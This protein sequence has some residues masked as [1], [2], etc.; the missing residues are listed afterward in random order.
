MTVMKSTGD[1]LRE[2][3]K[4][5]I[6]MGWA[7]FASWRGVPPVLLALIL[8]FAPL[9]RVIEPVLTRVVQPAAILLR[10]MA[11]GA[12]VAGTMHALSGATGIVSAQS[13]EGK[14][15]ESLFYRF[16]V[17]AP[18]I[19]KLYTGVGLPPGLTLNRL[20]GF[21][22]GVP[23][24]AGVF[25]ARLTAWRDS[26]GV[27]DSFTATVVFHIAGDLPPPIEIVSITPDRTVHLGEVVR[28]VVQA[29]PI[30]GELEYQWKRGSDDIPGA[31]EPFLVVATEEMMEGG[32][33]SVR[34]SGSGE[35]KDSDVIRVVVSGPLEARVPRIQI[36][37][38]L[39]DV[40][41]VAIA[42]RRYFLEHRV[43]FEGEGKD[44]RVIGEMLAE[45]SDGR[46]SVHGIE[47]AMGLFRLRVEPHDL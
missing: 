25:E 2:V 24:E 41:F 18:A 19:P 47:G 43:R 27:G 15:G 32:E 11:P 35:P 29:K 4:T 23:T 37:E 22:T 14:V 39:V 8:Q 1:V 45:T 21:V 17:N 6:G 31:T 30:E 33:F 20:T 5:P 28:L 42:G 16:Q 13:V 3:N 10:W 26:T 34:V 9:L 44:W 7:G 36:G 12:I 38:G 40:D 46:I